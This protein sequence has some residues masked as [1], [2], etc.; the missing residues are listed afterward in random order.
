MTVHTVFEMPRPGQDLATFEQAASLLSAVS[1]TP[2]QVERGYQVYIG[3]GFV[4]H[5]VRLA[6]LRAFVEE[7]GLQPAHVAAE[8]I[9]VRAYPVVDALSGGVDLKNEVPALYEDIMTGPITATDLGYFEPAEEP[10][11]ADLFS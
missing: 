5:E 2:E 8:A 6:A 10:A 4:S 3:A 7:E 1:L 9:L 11:V